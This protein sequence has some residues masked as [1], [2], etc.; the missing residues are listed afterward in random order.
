[1]DLK[2]IKEAVSLLQQ[3]VAALEARSTEKDGEIE[4]LKF[5]I[6][7]G[8][9]AIKGLYSKLGNVDF[10]I[11]SLEG[12]VSQ[13]ELN[14]R[15]L[16][17]ELRRSQEE[18]AM[19]NTELSEASAKV[20]ETEKDIQ[21]G[22]VK[23]VLADDLFQQTD[24]L[25]TFFGK[26]GEIATERK[27]NFFDDAKNFLMYRYG[28]EDGREKMLNEQGEEKLKETYPEIEWEKVKPLSFDDC[29]E[30]WSFIEGVQKKYSGKG[31][32]FKQD[33]I[34]CKFIKY[35]DKVFLE[36]KYVDLN[37]SKVAE[38]MRQYEDLRQIRDRSGF[39]AGLTWI[40]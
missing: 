26:F 31:V 12:R 40:D 24:Q 16:T 27:G 19:A 10:Q 35:Q 34:S 22:D 7:Q 1:M 29:G 5:Q 15:D 37:K 8:N 23:Y 4:S 6:Q 36:E 11:K 39:S 18:L 3:N 30:C 33:E 25:L 20:E 9:Q 14:I 13:L 2:N 21:V 38:A 17:S 32:G 28:L